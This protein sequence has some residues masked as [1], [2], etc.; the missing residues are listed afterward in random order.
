MNIVAF[1]STLFIVLLKV[2]SLVQNQNEANQIK[3]DAGSLKNR[4]Y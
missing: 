1:F 4:S 3:A 2:K